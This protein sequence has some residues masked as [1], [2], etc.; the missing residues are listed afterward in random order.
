M[1]CSSRPRSHR[2]S[3]IIRTATT[4]A[5]KSSDLTVLQYTS[6]TSRQLPEAVRHDHRAIVTLARAGLFALGLQE[7]DRYFCPSSPA[8]GHGLW[9]GTIAPWSIGV[10]LGS[11]SGRFA[12]EPLIDA[13]VDLRIT[14]LAA[15]STIYRMILRSG[16]LG[17]L[18][19]LTKA[20][21]TGEE[22]DPGAQQDF[23][24]ATGTS[25][26]GMYGTT[27]TG[28]VLGNYPGFSDYE[29]RIGALGKPLPGCELAVLDAD[30]NEVEA[31]I[32]GELAVKRRGEWFRSKDLS[33]IDDDGYF[34]YAGRA[35]DVI[36]ASGWTI[37]PVE[38][39]RTLLRHPDVVEAAV[40]GAPDELRGA[41]VKAVLVASRNDQELVA[42]LQ[43]MV[44]E[45]LSPH[46]YPRQIEFVD[47]LPKTPNGKVN[48]RAL[49]DS[50]N[51]G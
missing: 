8:W 33:R 27:E 45:Q 48:R 9:H 43:R 31:N 32:T 35:D 18:D 4:P 12:I 1:C 23:L 36:I 24:D 11:F 38:V 41:V 17:E 22:L 25:V 49:R 50:Q 5:S 28:V 6:G 3:A 42:D 40:I 21:Y 34:W 39:E 44:R 29:P 16:R 47:A 7:S 13:L 10:A 20:S 2:C 14:N 51:S 19:T 15:A 46:E 30:G 37:S 26:R